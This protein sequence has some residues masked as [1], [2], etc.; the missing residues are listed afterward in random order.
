MS[1]ISRA[2]TSL[3]VYVARRHQRARV[4]PDEK[5][6]TGAPMVLAPNLVGEGD[7]P[8]ICPRGFYHV[9]LTQLALF[10]KHEKGDWLHFSARASGRH[11]LRLAMQCV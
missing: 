1:S 2:L 8:E 3:C 9:S 4:L 11:Y 10:R 6:T 7:M 5:V